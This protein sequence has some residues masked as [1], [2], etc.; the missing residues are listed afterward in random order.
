MRLSSNIPEIDF[1][2]PGFD[3]TFTLAPVELN[4]YYSELSVEQPLFTGGRL[5]NQIQAAEHEGDAAALE[6]DQARVDLAFEIR[7]AYWQLYQA[8]AGRDAVRASLAQV[9]AHLQDVRNQREAGAALEGDVLTAQTRRSEV[10]L[11]RVDA[12]SAVRTTRL[13]LNRLTGLPLDAEVVPTGT[14]SMEAALGDVE[15]LIDQALDR[16]PRL[17]AWREQIAAL[18]AR[19]DAAQGGWFPEVLLNGRYVYA[20]PNDYFFTERSEFKGTWEAGAMLRWTIWDGGRRAAETDVAR[21]RLANAAARLESS[22]RS[23]AVDVMRGHLQIEHAAEAVEVAAQNVRQAE[24]AYRVMQRVYDEGAALSAD[25]LDAEQ[26]LSAARSRHVRAL[27][28]LAVAR[29]ALKHALGQI[30]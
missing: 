3:S 8:L 22:R 11:E 4:R 26:A 15:A 19:V 27:A 30:W 20:R 16:H 12:E 23:V 6:A 25:L 7:R 9:E 5:H 21:A 18:E 13:E 17:E 29:A 14:V 1:S 2:L 24:E 28:D 10:M